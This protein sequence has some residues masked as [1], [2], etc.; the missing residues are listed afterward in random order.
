MQTVATRLEELRTQLISKEFGGIKVLD[1]RPEISETL[2]GED[3]TRVW[4][5]LTP[6]NGETWDIEQVQQ[7]RRAVREAAR[8][9]ELPEAFV[10]FDAEGDPTG[11]IDA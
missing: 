8:V 3:R 9:L 2:E 1:V 6:P 11:D 4:L 7:L 5:L 10:R